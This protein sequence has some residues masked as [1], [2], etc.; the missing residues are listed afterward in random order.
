MLIIFIILC[1]K[2]GDWKNWKKYHSTF[3]FFIIGDL[4]LNLLTYKKPL[5][6]YFPAFTNHTIISLLID[7]ILFPC[8]ILVYIPHFPKLIINRILY[9]LMWVTIYT[10]MEIIWFMFGNFRYTNGWNIYYSAIFNC[11]LFPLLY[12]IGIFNYIS[13]HCHRVNFLS[14]RS[15]NNAIIGLVII[16]TQFSHI[17]SYTSLLNRLSSLGLLIYLT[18]SVNLA[19][20]FTWISKVVS[21]FYIACNSLHVF[22]SRYLAIPT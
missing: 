4:I 13:I 16:S 11:V 22:T 21:Y 17:F 10:T 19:T 18:V 8:T 20:L 15:R 9:I 1:Y 12:I 7:I 6:A 14:Y 2:Y 5:W 3:L